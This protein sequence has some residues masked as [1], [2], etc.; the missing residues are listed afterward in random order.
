M[1]FELL[2]KQISNS[3]FFGESGA[4]FTVSEMVIA[5]AILASGVILI[6]GAF[7]VAFDTTFSVGPRFIAAYLAQ[8]GQEIV[9][10]VRDTNFIN[11]IEWT[12]GLTTD[13]CGTTGCQLDYHIQN[14]SQI[15]RYMRYDEN[16]YL[17]L[18]SDGFYSYDAV[19]TLTKFRR[20]ILVSTIPDKPD[21]IKVTVTVD[22][23]YRE[24]PFILNTET[25]LYKWY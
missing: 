18:N 11:N 14:S 25:Y 3:H 15:D 22:W 19:V 12:T 2:R 24:K 9:R 20:K 7:Y 8:E 5:V 17:R 21:V 4:G 1:V 6:Y 10:G 23:T 13:P 16:A